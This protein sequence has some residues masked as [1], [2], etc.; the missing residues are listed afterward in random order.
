MAITT[1]TFNVSSGFSRGDVI[2]QME[3]ALTWL[4]WHADTSSGLTTGISARSGGGTVGSAS[5]DYPEVYPISSSR[6]VGIGST[7]SFFVDRSSGDIQRVCVNRPGEGYQTGDTFVISAEDIGGSAHGAT[8]I[9]VTGIV[10]TSTYG[11][12]S[13]FFDKEVSGN[14][15][16]GICKKVDNVNKV[17]GTTYKIF[18]IEDSDE[19][20][21]HDVSGFMPY[22]RF[23]NLSGGGTISDDKSCGAGGRIAGHNYL[24][25]PNQSFFTS[26][27]N[28]NQF[29]P[30]NALS[31]HY[32][33]NPKFCDDNT[34]AL[35][36]NV[37]RSAIDTNFVVFA[38][39]QGDRPATVFQDNNYGCFFFHNF[40]S[41]MF[42][43]DELYV[44]GITQIIPDNSGS[45]T[46]PMLQFEMR[47]SEVDPNDDVC[48][49]SFLSGYATG[50]SAGSM[51]TEIDSRYAASTG[52]LGLSDFDTRP[53]YR[54]NATFR[55][56]D[57]NS[58]ENNQKLPDSTNYNAVIKG[59]PLSTNIIPCPY[60]LPDDFVLINFEN[61]TPNQNIQQGDTITISGSEKYV[62]ISASY[63]TAS[64]PGD[65]NTCGI[66]F[67]GRT[68]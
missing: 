30:N 25:L 43:L 46:T 55:G 53:Y 47:P 12:S 65:T 50:A 62:I 48:W 6:T 10:T 8:N 54:D 23:T 2:T 17:Y 21:I 32:A 60:Y 52:E 28:G 59:I 5:T 13:T 68:V 37:Y 19:I 27:D 9:N 58:G 26:I 45:S 35:Q 38:Y 61:S 7:V 11:T 29:V 57:P 49:R 51:S 1:N 39:R 16:Y 3:S 14:N 63:N 4:G 67:C 64:G 36:L 56:R 41:S 42:D 15:P 31:T 40:T 33:C 44:T 22:R 18:Q 66:A 34:R 20:Y 24:D